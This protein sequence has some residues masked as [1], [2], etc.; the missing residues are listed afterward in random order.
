MAKC[1]EL[2]ELLGIVMRRQNEQGV[3]IAQL[4]AQLRFERDQHSA[5]RETHATQVT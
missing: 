5:L 1:A 2:R 3:E 4:R